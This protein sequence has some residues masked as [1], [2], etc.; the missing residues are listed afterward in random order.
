MSKDM[1][2]ARELVIQIFRRRA[3]LAKGVVTA[4]AL[5]E[6]HAW[7]VQGRAER[8]ACLQSSYRGGESS[9][10]SSEKLQSNGGDWGYGVGV[11]EGC[12]EWS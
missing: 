3:F 7:R 5:S 4:K 1:K 6:E 8:P 9:D 11:T 12:E 10:T 2:Q